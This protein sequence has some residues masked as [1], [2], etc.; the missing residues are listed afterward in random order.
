MDTSQCAPWLITVI[1]A[2][3]TSLQG[4]ACVLKGGKVPELFPSVLM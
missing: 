1:G 3:M 2:E 4:I